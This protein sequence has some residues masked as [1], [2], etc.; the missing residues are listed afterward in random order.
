MAL[1]SASKISGMARSSLTVHA[2]SA[3]AF[4]N[5]Q[6]LAVGSQQ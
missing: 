5:L 6:N 2:S 3:V 4:P 1:S